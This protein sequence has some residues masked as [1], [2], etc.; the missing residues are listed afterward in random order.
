[1]RLA[2]ESRLDLE[3]ERG[4]LQEREEE[5]SYSPLEEAKVESLDNFMDATPCRRFGKKF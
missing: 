3:R 1:M 2:E 4:G 5:I